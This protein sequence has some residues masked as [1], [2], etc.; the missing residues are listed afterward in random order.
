MRTCCQTSEVY[1]TPA[2]VRRIEAHT[3]Q[4]D[5]FEYRVPDDPVYYQHDDDPI[6]PKL[7]FQPDG[8][9]RV[10]RREKDGNCTFLGER[11]CELPIDVRPLVCRIYPYNYNEEGI[12]DALCTGC[13]SE[14]LRPGQTLTKALV[15]N[16]A[17]AE[18]WRK[19][20]YEDIVEE[21]EHHGEHLPKPTT[22]CQPV[23]DAMTVD[24]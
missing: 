15:M 19:Q 11:G 20:L 18:A 10:L 14:L 24:T 5:F 6:W 2:D 23:A 12:K 7:V 4:S 17:E 1:A 13:P 22:D 21:L 8:T 16:R 9:R 3:G